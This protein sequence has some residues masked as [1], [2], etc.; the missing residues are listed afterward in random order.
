LDI[1]EGLKQL[2]I[3]ADVTIE[4]IINLGYREVSEMLHIDLYVSELIIKAA[5]KI[6]TRKKSQSRYNLTIVMTTSENR[7]D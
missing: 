4:S 5:Q 3:D 1:A 2:L 6:R 7:I